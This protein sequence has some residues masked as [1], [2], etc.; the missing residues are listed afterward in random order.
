MLRHALS[1]AAALLA[2]C[3]LS[4][5]GPQ[6]AFAQYTENPVLR[7]PAAATPIPKRAPPP[8]QTWSPVPPPP[9]AIRHDIPWPSCLQAPCNGPPIISRP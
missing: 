9:P 2:G 4:F 6:A 7:R 3:A 1:I 8:P 5:A